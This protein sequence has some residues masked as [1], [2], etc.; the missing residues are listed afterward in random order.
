[1]EGQGDEQ[2]E[3]DIQIESQMDGQ[4]DGQTQADIQ[5]E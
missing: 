5:I 4:A 3:A 1:M 2:T